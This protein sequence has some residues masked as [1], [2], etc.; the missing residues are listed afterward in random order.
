M[1]P[2]FIYGLVYV[3]P[4]KFTLVFGAEKLQES[5]NIL[6]SF[7]MYLPV[8]T[9][10]GTRVGEAHCTCSRLKCTTTPGLGMF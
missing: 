8:C 7:H 6:E 4:T 2:Q 1:D 10:V 5:T 3:E 9:Y